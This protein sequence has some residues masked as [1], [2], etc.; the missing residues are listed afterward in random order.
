MADIVGSIFGL[1]SQ[2]LINKQRERDQQFAVNVANIYQNPTDRLGALIG[3]SLGGGLARGLFNIQDPQ[4]KAAQDF[5]A[6]LAEAQQSST[7]PA[8]AMMKLAEKLGSDPRFSRQAAMAKMK[9]Q[10]LEQ[11]NSLNQA[12]I[13]NE[14]AQSNKF[15]AEALKALRQDD[16]VQKLFFEMAK[17]ATPQS[18]ARAIKA[19]YAIDMLDS[20]EKVKYSPLAQQLI[21]AGYV[22]GSPQFNAKMLEFLEA[23]KAGKSKGSGNVNVNLGG[24]SPQINMGKVAEEAGK[25]LGKKLIDI[26]TADKAEG[27]V[28][29]ALS[30][31][32]AGISSGAM[33]NFKVNLAKY[34]SE[35][36][37][38]IGSI[39]RA[40]NTEI[41]KAYLGN[42]VIPMMSQL[43][44][45]DSNE[46]LKKMEAIL[47]SDV[48]LEERSMRKILQQ[49]QAAIQR[50]RAWTEKQ[51]KAGE[52]G[53]RIPTQLDQSPTLKATKRYNPKTGKIEVIK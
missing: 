33:A 42:V 41:Y 12:K 16:P 28:K 21:D 45:S 46:E 49:A 11:A 43:G 39:E 5:E 20:P 32:D 36:G 44:G 10:E 7:N 34:S 53:T 9:A 3:A 17:N 37:I 1:S 48:T 4:I 26:P 22:Y 52:E 25:S 18:V 23:E 31:L 8:E 35:L 51:Q 2:D 30:M 14:E 15:K 47:A 6:A 19:G 38:P 27:Y 40:S 13:A 24:I 50:D 29:E